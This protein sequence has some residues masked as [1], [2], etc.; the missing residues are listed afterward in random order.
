MTLQTVNIGEQLTRFSDD[1]LKSTFHRVR[2]PGP[3]E[4]KVQNFKLCLI[5]YVSVHAEGLDGWIA[6]F[7]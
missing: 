7:L 5:T 3:D 4:Y 2:Q 6:G 1:K